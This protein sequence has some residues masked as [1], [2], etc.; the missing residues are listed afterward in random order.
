MCYIYIVK[1]QIYKGHDV[2]SIETSFNDIENIIVTISGDTDQNFNDLTEECDVMG[3]TA[4]GLQSALWQ[5]KAIFLLP[6]YDKES[7][8]D[9]LKVNIMQLGLIVDV[10][11]KEDEDVVEG[12]EA[13]WFT[14]GQRNAFSIILLNLEK[15]EVD[16]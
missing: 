2:R 13:L 15:S 1:K 10:L 11:E 5:A 8:I 9:Y 14:A 6:E 12:P 16:E 3:W 4:R 7:F